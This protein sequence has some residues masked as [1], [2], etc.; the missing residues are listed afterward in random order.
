MELVMHILYAVCALSVV[1]YLGWHFRNR[2]TNCNSRAAWTRY[3]STGLNYSS[4]PSY[5]NKLY[6][7]T[8]IV[9]CICGFVEGKLTHH[10]RRPFLITD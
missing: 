3:Y 5:L 8:Y 2:C 10:I 1:G 9:H 4:N 6:V 7:S